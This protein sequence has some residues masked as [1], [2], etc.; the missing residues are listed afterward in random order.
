MTCPSSTTRR[1]R[2]SSTCRTRTPWTSSS[3]TC[4]ARPCARKTSTA[5]GS[6]SGWTSK[7]SWKFVTRWPYGFHNGTSKNR[8]FKQT[9]SYLKFGTVQQEGNGLID[10]LLT[11]LITIP[12]VRSTVLFNKNLPCLQDDL[13][14]M[15]L[16]KDNF[17][18]NGMD[19]LIHSV[20]PKLVLM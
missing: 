17:W 1:S 19:I 6:S 3:G 5:T 20:L 9:T 16:H 15:H 7:A 11:L 10:P 14:R 8:L 12:I 13:K 2:T 18:Q 4:S